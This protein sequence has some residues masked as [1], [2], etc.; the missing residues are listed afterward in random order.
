MNG[1][2]DDDPFGSLLEAEIEPLFDVDIEIVEELDE[3]DLL[4]QDVGAL[5]DV[6]EKPNK[7]AQ[8]Q[9]E[10]E[11]GC[12]SSDETNKDI[13]VQCYHRGCSDPWNAEFH[14]GYA[15]PKQQ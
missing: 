8:T 9:N 14:D 5:E 6:P 13:L 2:E 4:L 1:P 7:L 11:N 12:N 15:Q 3:I 10:N